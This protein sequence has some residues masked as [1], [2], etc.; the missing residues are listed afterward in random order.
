VRRVIEELV[1]MREKIDSPFNLVKPNE[2][3]LNF[4][5]NIGVNSV[6]GIFKVF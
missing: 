3:Y 1:T 2:A 5:S 6:N 4:S